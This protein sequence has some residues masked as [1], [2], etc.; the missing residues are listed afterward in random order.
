MTLTTWQTLWLLLRFGRGL[1]LFNLLI[2]LLLYA[3][4]LVPGLIASEVFSNLTD[5][6]RTGLNL[7]SLIT[8]LVV[9]TIARQ[10]C[11]CVFMVSNNLHRHGLFA[12]MRSNL[13]EFILQKPGARSL[14]YSTGEAISRFRDDIHSLQS[15]MSAA[16]HLLSS[17]CAALIAASIML[18][19]NLFLTIAVFVPLTLVAILINQSR[20]RIVRYRTAAQ[21]ATGG[22]TGAL[23]EMFGA[24]QTIKVADAEDNVI[25]HLDRLNAER[26]E[27]A[28]KDR[29]LTELMRSLSGNIGDLGTGL[30]LLLIGQSMLAGTF[31]LGDFALFVYFLPWISNLTNAVSMVLTN[32]RQLGVSFERLFVLL[33][34]GPND[35]LVQQRPVYMRREPP[36]FSE[37]AGSIQTD[38]SLAN[39]NEALSNQLT[40]CEVKNLSYLYPDSDRGIHD[41]NLQLQSGSFT[42]VT[43]RIGAGKTT[44]LRTFLGLLPKSSGEIRWNGTIVQDPATFFVPPRS[45]YVPQIPRLFSDS[46][47]DNI[48]LG[49]EAPDSQ[50][51]EVLEK[52]VMTPDLATMVQGLDTLVGPRGV[53]LSGGQIQ[54]TAVAR[55]LVRHPQLLAIDDLS[56]ALD[57]ETEQ[58]LWKRLF[59]ISDGDSRYRPTCLVVSHRQ[60]ALQRADQIIVLKVRESRGRGYT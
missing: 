47:R 4:S 59:A 42:V 57:V 53:R 31:T 3:L 2:S 17:L 30:I 7:W 33:Q 40:H 23:G 41:A 6:A 39:G 60:A 36:S 5:D 43:G 49:L 19:I 1:L 58:Q 46:L 21:Q 28:L 44:F 54:R 48:L 29:M 18:R 56:S 27:A 24:V 34:D 26:S 37:V 55:M 12:L 9:L 38:N 8:L 11:Y 45:A 10:T 52:A 15:F 51:I 16:Y 13:L 50:L 20:K 35:I 14:P 22:V 32:Y 25:A